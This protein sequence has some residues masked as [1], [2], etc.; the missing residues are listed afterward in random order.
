[1]LTGGCVCGAVRYRA[2]GA[3]EL[4]GFCHCRNCQKFSGSGH[5]GFICFPRDAV[6]IEGETQAYRRV[7]GSGL[8]AERHFC[9]TCCSALFGFTEMMPG[10]MNIYAGS[11]DDL[12]QFKPKIAIFTRSRQPWDRA[13]EGLLSFSTL[14][15]S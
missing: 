12:T 11:L 3:P 13:S 4:Q 5:V 8:P 6:T 2:E 15:T 10:K 14:P 7:G 1:M 9:P